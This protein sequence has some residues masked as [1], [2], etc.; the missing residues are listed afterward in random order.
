MPQTPEQIINFFVQL[1]AHPRY[2][3]D[4]A[5]RNIVD[6]YR[7]RLLDAASFIETNT[8]QDALEKCIK[9]TLYDL[10]F[11]LSEYKHYAQ[12]SI[13]ASFPGLFLREQYDGQLNLA[14]GSGMFERESGV[15]N[16]GNLHD[17]IYE[18]PFFDRFGRHFRMPGWDEVKNALL[19]NRELVKEKSSQGFTK[20]L[21]VPFGYNLK[22][23]A[24]HFTGIFRA[25]NKKSGIFD[26]WGNRIFFNDEQPHLNQHI[27]DDNNLVYQPSI[28]NEKTHGG[29]SKADAVIE[30]GAWQ[31]CLVEDLP[32]IPKEIK[33]PPNL[34]H[35]P[36]IVGGRPRMDI[37]GD[38]LKCYKPQP[39]PEKKSIK[40]LN[41]F[42]NREGE[43]LDSPYFAERGITA[44]VYFWLILSGLLETGKAV[45]WDIDN[46]PKSLATTK[47][48]FTENYHPSTKGIPGLD[49]FAADGNRIYRFC[50]YKQ[51]S[52]VDIGTRTRVLLK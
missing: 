11:S 12:D 35:S 39:D 45:L 36:D 41:N 30:D 2:S 22:T 5:V 19:N 44:E 23:L 48:F 50:S 42:L 20:L 17:C 7:D 3:A 18:F 46:T 49:S 34:D 16:F 51:V 27:Y 29:M 25:I 6:H 28:Y 52:S 31:I 10:R 40:Q 4:A 8:E 33:L 38:F 9:Q 14:L 37:N 1:E 47:I 26:P 21:I 32:L 13:E 24:G 15:Q 43:D